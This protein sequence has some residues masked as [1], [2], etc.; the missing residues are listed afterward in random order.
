M[1]A[2]IAQSLNNDSVCLSIRASGLIFLDLAKSGR[3]PERHIGCR[4]RLPQCV[5]QCHLSLGVYQSRMQPR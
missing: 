3:T 5:P 1:V 2:H 4:V